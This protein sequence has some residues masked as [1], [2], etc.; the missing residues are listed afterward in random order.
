MVENTPP[1]R[2]NRELLLKLAAAVVVLGIAA[3]LVLRG[4]DVKALIE[5]GLDLLRAAGPV[6]FFVGMALAPLAAVPMLAFSLPAVAL[7]GPQFGTA[8]VVAL[9]LGAVTVNFCL[10]Y[11]LAR[12]ALR[13]VLSA[14]VTR[15]GY[16]LPDVEAGD[17]TDL[18]I[19]LRVTPGIP[20]FAQNFLAGLAE[21]PFG[22]YFLVSALTAWPLNVAF[23]LFGDALLHGKGKVALV[24]F[25]A[26]AALVTATHLVRKHYERR[27]KAA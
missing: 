16:R 25:C 6:A 17:A 2:I 20:F 9:A 22:R 11:A 4:I 12:R 23:L 19:L 24:S 13:P 10:S 14:I 18:V 27:K 5:R 26:L 21:V 3:V 7:Y 15:L 1:S 8:G